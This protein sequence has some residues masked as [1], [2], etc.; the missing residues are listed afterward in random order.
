[1]PIE[2]DRVEWGFNYKLNFKVMAVEEAAYKL[3]S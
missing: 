3:R 2:S 1:M